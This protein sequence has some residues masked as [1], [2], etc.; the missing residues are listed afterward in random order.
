[1]RQLTALFLFLL[2]LLILPVSA[3][4]ETSIY[5]DILSLQLVPGAYGWI[6]SHVRDLDAGVRVT[7]A[8]WESTDPEVVEVDSGG[9]Y[10]AVGRGSAEILRKVKTSDGNTWE[11]ACRVQVVVPVDSIAFSVSQVVIMEGTSV[12]LPRVKVL[13]KD[14]DIRTCSFSV[15]REDI[16]RIRDGRLYGVKAGRAVL[17]A[18][19]DERIEKRLVRTDTCTVL[20][21]PAITSITL[22]EDTLSLEAGGQKKLQVHL[23]PAGVS[24]EALHFESSDQKVCTVDSQGLVSGIAPGT[25]KILVWTDQ[26]AQGRLEASLEV[27]VFRPLRRLTLS[28]PKTVIHRGE[29]VTFTAACDPGDAA[30]SSYTWQSSNPYSA[31]FSDASPDSPKAGITGQQVGLTT[32]SCTAAGINRKRASLRLRVETDRPLSIRSAS[33]SDSRLLLTVKNRMWATRIHGMLLVF[34]CLDA[35]GEVLETWDMS[36][37]D[38]NLSAA[39]FQDISLKVTMPDAMSKAASLDVTVTQVLEENGKWTIPENRRE[40]YRIP[41]TVHADIQIP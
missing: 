25:A 20:V 15:D 5:L 24:L 28:V 27:Q 31:D 11:A 14:A 18:Q 22:P 17:T 34:S 30:V 40:T 41:L 1:M 23:E 26:T 29:T 33:L 37:S 16:A 21:V 36:V 19:S 38:L 39:Q 9:K 32:V 13:P 7:S 2:F 35:S 4:A 10:R 3:P 12:S 6:N 8:V